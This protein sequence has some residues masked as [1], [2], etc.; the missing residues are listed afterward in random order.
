VRFSPNPLAT[1]VALVLLFVACCTA[2]GQYQPPSAHLTIR[3]DQASTW[4]EDHAVV[5]FSDGPVT[6]ETDRAT[7]SAKQAVIWL[8]PVRGSVLDEQEAQI[9]LIGNATLAQ[10]SEQVTRSGD[11]LF[12]TIVVRG[13]VRIVSERRLAENHSDTDLYR[14]ATRM[15]PLGGMAGGAVE[16]GTLLQRPWIEVLPTT[17][18]TTLPTTRPLPKQPVNFRADHI[19]S[20]MTPDGKVAFVL[21]GNVI[22]FQRRANGDLVE[23]QADRAVIFTQLHNLREVGQDKQVGAAEDAVVSAYCEGDVRVAFSPGS[24]KK[25]EQRL[26]A[27]RVYYEFTTDRAI[28]TQASVHT[29]EPQRQFPITVRANVVRQLSVGEYET[30]DV[31]LSTSQFATPSYSVNAS[32]MY[33]RQ[34]ETGDVRYGNYTEFTANN[35]TLNLFGLPV[36]WLPVTGG[37]FTDRGMALRNIFLEGNSRFGLGVRSEWGLFET[38]GLLPPE[39]LD[40]GY[41]LDFFEKRGFA[42]GLQADYQGGFITETTKQAWDFQG[43]FTGYFLPNDTGVDKLGRDRR[44]VEPPDSLRGRVLWEHQHFFPQDWQLQLRAGYSSDPTF[45][46]EYFER[47]F[48]TGQPHDFSAYAKR[49]R[50]T[51]AMTLLVSVPTNLF[52]TAANEQQEQVGI[53]RIPEVSYR[54]IGDS[55]ADDSFTFFSDNT[56]SLLD[57]RRTTASL[58]EQGFRPGQSPGIPSYGQTGVDDSNNLRGDFR[59]EVDYPFSAGPLKIV[60]FVFGRYT[61]Y[62]DTPDDGSRSRYFVGTGVRINTSFWKVD[63]QAHSELFD[64]HRLRH[65]IEPEINLFTSAQSRDA[66]RFFI[67]DENVDAINDVSAVQVALHQRWQTKRG[68]AG[69][70][71]SVDFFSLNIE[72]NLFANQPS[73]LFRNPTGF[74]GLFFPSMPE[75]SVPRNSINADALWR[76]SDTTA[77]LADGQYNLDQYELATTSIGLA[78]QR[79]PRLSYFVGTRYIGEINS[80]IASFALSYELSAKYALL[81]NQSYSISERRNQNSSVTLVRHF[82]RLFASITLYYD[83]VDDTSGFR[84]GITPEGLGAGVSSDAL[85]QIFGP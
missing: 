66:D 5:V 38:L 50:D 70:F 8:T 30:K 42:A 57:F 45:L 4:N 56:V 65:V 54:R 25:P 49:Q 60:P 82:D 68:G 40:V 17:Q 34:V 51:E 81:L 79:D 11:R 64:I 2:F 20:V 84:F 61:G 72:A 12:V 41:R 63:D 67:Y 85:G 18:P 33:V 10:P 46:E 59:Q 43:K 29:V 28:L 19:D 1:G 7:M 74:R 24:S 3:T 21:S 16:P 44:N 31:Q 62:T 22:V 83:A 73:D 53:E 77:I 75:A 9:S 48:D 27:E 15:R 35:M 69:Q 23:L 80:T 26:S 52:P 14:Q 37:S 58:V 76:V 13:S 55:F 71:R 78:V 6:I 32:R 36:F 39:D 47:E